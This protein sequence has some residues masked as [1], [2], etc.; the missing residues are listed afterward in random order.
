MIR[1][2][3][4]ARTSQSAS[5]KGVRPDLVHQLK[6]VPAFAL[7]LI[8]STLREDMDAVRR[9]GHGQRAIRICR[10]RCL[11][12]DQ[13]LAA[14]GFEEMLS[15]CAEIERAG[16]AARYEVFAIAGS[17]NVAVLR[18]DHDGNFLADGHG[19]REICG[20]DLAKGSLDQQFSPNR[21][22]NALKLIG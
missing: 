6:P 3:M 21:E 10:H 16:E 14:I 20:F 1:S 2:A 22:D 8:S 18:A 12:R 9:A 7:T 4:S 17:G 19:C 11:R 13:Q 15:N 5:E